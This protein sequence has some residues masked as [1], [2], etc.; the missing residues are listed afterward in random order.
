MNA[1][2][3]PGLNAWPVLAN[4]LLLTL[5]LVPVVVFVTLPLV[6]RAATARR[7]APSAGT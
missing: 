1:L 2:V 3:M 4:T 7:P 6:N 5:T